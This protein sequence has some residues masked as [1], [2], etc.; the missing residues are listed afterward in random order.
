TM[1]WKTTL[2]SKISLTENV[3]NSFHLGGYS[4]L[5]KRT[6]LLILLFISSLNL[7]A[8][9]SANVVVG[10]DCITFDSCPADQTICATDIVEGVLGAYV[11]W[12]SPV[13]SQTCTGNGN[14]GN[15]QMLFEL[16]EK[17]LVDEC[18]D[19]NYITRAGERE[20]GYL[21]LFN[22][23][24]EAGSKQAVVTTPYLILNDNSETS[25]EI[26]H[27]QGDYTIQLFLVNEAGVEI[28]S[29]GPQAVNKQ[30]STY[31]FFTLNP[32][33]ETGVFRLKYVFSYTGNKPSNAN[34]GDT[35]IAVDGI[36][37]EDGCSGGIDFTVTG[38]K[39]GFY[40]VGVHELVYVATYATEGGAPRT[41]TCSFTITV[42]GPAVAD[43]IEDKASCDSYIL[44]ALSTGNKYFTGSEGT[45]TELSTGDTITSTQP[46]YIY[47]P[48][49]GSCPADETSFTVTINK[50]PVAATLDD[51][52]TC[53]SYSLPAISIGNQYFTGPGAT[54]NELFEGSVIT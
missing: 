18:W 40:P 25:F 3:K 1:I 49:N 53:E 31:T 47:A 50:T 35:L 11:D 36:L 28:P 42:D 8:Q 2:D 6:T 13:V 22:S 43:I 9:Q 32:N 37:H 41:K 12:Q 14:E 15:F 38:P 45:G 34:V 46:I 33:D 54:G 52:E 44:P 23:N 24:D 20:G 5:K 39:K 21:K 51:L 17:Q 29:G 10:D 26:Q 7:S 30:Q 48:E 4:A 27:A 16:N 19:F